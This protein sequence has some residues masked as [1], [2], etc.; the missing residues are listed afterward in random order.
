M[1]ADMKRI[2]TAVQTGRRVDLAVDG[3]ERLRPSSDRI[4]TVQPS[5]SRLVR[6]IVDREEL[7]QLIDDGDELC[8]AAR[9]ALTTQ[10]ASRIDALR[11]RVREA[12][13]D[14][15]LTITAEGRLYTPDLD[16]TALVLD[17]LSGQ[18]QVPGYVDGGYDPKLVCGECLEPQPGPHKGICSQSMMHGGGRIES[19][20]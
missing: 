14:P 11:A 6:V 13:L 18:V 3:P 1:D 10:D 5:R 2:I 8:F 16:A 19:S 20:P 7:K 4:P 12:G 15:A 9:R 17:R